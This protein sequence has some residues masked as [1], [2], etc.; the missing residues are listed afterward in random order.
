M[1]EKIAAVTEMAKLAEK[2]VL[3][4]ARD[5]AMASTEWEAHQRKERLAQ[6]G[7]DYA[8]AKNALDRLIRLQRISYQERA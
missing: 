3:E 5:Y 1:Q 4:A 7:I 8:R 2:R 6:A